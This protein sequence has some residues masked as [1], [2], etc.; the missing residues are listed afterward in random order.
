MKYKND[1]KQRLSQLLSRGEI[2]TILADIQQLAK[3]S[4]KGLKILTFHETKFCAQNL[5]YSLLE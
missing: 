2:K 4:D 5:L 3:I 1:K